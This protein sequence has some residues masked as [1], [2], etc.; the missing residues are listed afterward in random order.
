MSTG[1]LSTSR[2]Q[3]L[4]MTAMNV[5]SSV[6]P[7]AA[8]RLK[9]QRVSAHAALT[10]AHKAGR[11]RLE[12]LFQEGAAKIR[13]PRTDADPLEAVLIN[14]AGGLTGNDR[15]SWEVEVGNSSAAV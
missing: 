11:T 1:S 13:M 8:A 7:D 4:I 12:R 15:L 5:V 3:R 10:V 9:S 14:T 2:R 6:E